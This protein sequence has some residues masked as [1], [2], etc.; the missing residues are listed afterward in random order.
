MSS[1]AKC[2]FPHTAAGGGKS[3][4]DWW[5]DQL[6]LRILHQQSQLSDPMG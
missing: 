4:R 6:N 3:N 2:P 5:P 1:D